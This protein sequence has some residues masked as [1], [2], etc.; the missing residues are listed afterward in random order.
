MPP[1]KKKLMMTFLTKL[2]LGFKI[3]PSETHIILGGRN[4]PGQKGC[5]MKRYR[6]CGD[7]RNAKLEFT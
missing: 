6:E 4:G 5:V 2:N 7:G 1:P 3:I